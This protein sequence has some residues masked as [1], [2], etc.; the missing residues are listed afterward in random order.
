MP[1]LSEKQRRMMAVAY[2]QPQKLFKKNRRVL[3]MSRTQ[4]HDFTLKTMGSGYPNLAL[5]SAPGG[6]STSAGAIGRID[7]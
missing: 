3:K 2:N 1:A 7:D 4:L 6:S 5:G